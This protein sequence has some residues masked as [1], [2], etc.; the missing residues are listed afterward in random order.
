MRE[1]GFISQRTRRDRVNLGNERERG[2]PGYDPQV[3]GEGYESPSKFVVDDESA[4]FLSSVSF[5]LSSDQ[6]SFACLGRYI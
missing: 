1:V 3:P 4:Y 6:E 5:I 2:S